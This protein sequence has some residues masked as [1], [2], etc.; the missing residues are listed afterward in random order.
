MSASGMGRVATKE[1][2][3]KL[4]K[5]MIGNQYGIG[6]KSMGGK[7]HTKEA[8]AKMSKPV[9]QYLNGK[10]VARFSSQK[11]AG[12]ITGV[13]QQHIS[14]CCHGKSKTAGGFTWR[15]TKEGIKEE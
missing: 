3:E 7:N 11:D 4:A 6:N 1:T 5:A 12:I 2:R 8:K 14:N 9:T 13:Y 15:F 10:E